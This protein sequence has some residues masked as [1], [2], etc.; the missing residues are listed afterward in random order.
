M[1]FR[2]NIIL[3]VFLGLSVFVTAQRINPHH[4]NTEEAIPTSGLELALVNDTTY[5]VGFYHL[6][7]EIELDSSYIKGQ[8]SFLITSLSDN[9]NSL[10]LDLDSAFQVDSISFPASSFD[11]SNDELNIELSNT[12]NANEVI[13]FSVYYHGIPEL[14]GDVK[15]LRYETHDNNEIVIASLATPYLAHT[16]WPCKDGTSDKADSVYI[17]ISIKDTV[18]NSLPV[19]AVSN[20]LLDETE[21]TNGRKIFRWKH[22]YPVVPFYVM[23]AI[24]NYEHFQQ[25]FNGQGYSF[26]MDYYVFNSY[27]TASQSGVAEMPDVMEFFTNTFGPY[28]FLTEKYGM[29]QLGYYGGIENQTNSIVNNMGLSWFNVSVHELAHQWF[30]DMITCQT[31]NHGWLNEGFAS[32][33]EALY[34]E[35]SEGF[36]PYQAYMADFEFYEEGTLYLDDVS[37]PFNVFRPIIYNKGAYVLHMLRG[38]MGDETFFAALLSYTDDSSIRYGNATTEDF[39]LIC[40]VESGMDLQYF[41]EQWIYDQRYPRYRYNYIQDQGTGVLDLSIVQTQDQQ[42]WR[43]I[44]VMPIE[45]KVEFSDGSDTIVKVFNDE[46]YE[47][48]SFNLSGEVSGV[49]LDPDN[50]ILKFALIDNN[51]DVGI[52]KLESV[53]FDVFPNPGT[54]VFNIVL[55]NTTDFEDAIL[56]V[57][58]VNGELQLE[59]VLRNGSNVHEIDLHPLNAGVYFVQ[60]ETK[61]GFNQQKLLILE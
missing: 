32:Y 13:S 55:G 37:G 51:L 23:V 53:S 35:H 44:F 48:F 24:S 49:E 30:A 10:K 42:G 16:W 6:D 17:D 19:I 58:S 4:L 25:T 46:Q 56:K 7:L 31:W 61:S 20:G 34:K 1:I 27:L 26:P 38:V 9:F 22:S 54:G 36:A 50:W 41:F 8:V 45:V 33:A 5:D 3:A 14:E 40:E 60:I 59:S 39:Q 43:S 18:V 57:I 52:E 12:Y 15:G 28:P 47:T 11:H 2:F 21:T 29:T